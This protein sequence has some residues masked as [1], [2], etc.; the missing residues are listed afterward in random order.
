M[1]VTGS[2]LMRTPNDLHNKMFADYEYRHKN[3]DLNVKAIIN[4]I[5]SDIFKSVATVMSQELKNERAYLEKK[6]ENMRSNKKDR[7]NK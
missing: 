6:S 1:T 3:M 4:P 7:G 2:Y 5:I